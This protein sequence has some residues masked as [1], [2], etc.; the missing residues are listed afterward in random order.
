MASG[1]STLT[2]RDLIR[3]QLY[4]R[5][6]KELILDDLFAMQFVRTL[7]EFPDGTTFNI[8]SLGQAMTQTFT[9][10]QAIRYEKLDTGNFTFSFDTYKYSAHSISAKFKRDSF[11]S[12]I[13]ESA[14]LPR[15]HRALMEAVE[16][17][18]LNKAQPGQTNGQVANDLNLINNG[19][20][21]WI[22]SG[23]NQALA[24][25]DFHK[26]R[27]SLTK[28]LM[29]MSRLVCILDPS[30]AYSLATQT[31]AISLLTPMPSYEMI[32]RE[33]M[34]SGFKFVYS[35]AGFD[36]YVSNYL[37]SGFSETINS[38]TVSSGVA[39]LFFSAAPGDTLPIIGGFRQMP[40][41]YS[42]FNKDLQQ[43]EYLTISEWGWKLYRPENMIT[44]LT[45]ALS[46]VVSW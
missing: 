44:I 20:H 25:D 9:E 29:P 23:T 26:A 43:D 8:P 19:A 22:G 12:G 38:K 31:N 1:F 15:E 3:S 16:A 39:N 5:Q 34:Q 30:T 32:I 40:Q 14:F 36:C 45:G 18:V 11:W 41:V 27:L 21:R 42:E 37:P 4:S 17:D 28:A 7:T 6:L 35:F 24:I 10:G 46:S 13:V 2:N 33:G